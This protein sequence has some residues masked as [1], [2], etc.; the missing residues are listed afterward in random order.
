MIKQ[1][2]QRIFEAEYRTEDGIECKT[3]GAGSKRE[4]YWILKHIHGVEERKIIQVI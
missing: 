1:S 2:K 3:I 4:V